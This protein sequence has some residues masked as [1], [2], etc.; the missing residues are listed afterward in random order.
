MPLRTAC[1]H[2]CCTPH[3]HRQQVRA[4]QHP[5]AHTLRT[6]RPRLRLR[7]TLNCPRSRSRSPCCSHHRPRLHPCPCCPRPQSC[8]HGL[9]R[10]GGQGRAGRQA[11][12][13]LHSYVAVVRL[14]QQQ[15]LRHVRLRRGAERAAGGGGERQEREALRQAGWECGEVEAAPPVKVFW[16][17]RD[18]DVKCT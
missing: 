11:G 12:Q 2:D 4:V 7:T 13:G 18:K 10:P 8:G 17:C 9:V 3:T 16:L 14:A 6:A 15:Q 1:V 5:H